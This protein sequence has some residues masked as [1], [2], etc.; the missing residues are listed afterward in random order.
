MFWPELHDSKFVQ[1]VESSENVLAFGPVGCSELRMFELL[2]LQTLI[3]TYACRDVGQNE[4]CM[5][6]MG[7]TPL[8]C[9]AGG[10][11]SCSG[12]DQWPPS[13]M[14]SRTDHSLHRSLSWL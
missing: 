10:T 11:Y 12:A 7:K 13:Y 4:R 5:R 1:A 3:L 9:R 2:F 14:S 8:P 6:H